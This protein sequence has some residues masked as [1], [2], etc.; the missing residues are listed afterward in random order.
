MHMVETNGAKIPALGLGTWRLTGSE[1]TRLVKEALRLGYRHFDT[2]EMYENEAEIGRGIRESGVRREEVFVT[3]KIWSTHLAPKAFVNAT[4]A[5]IKRL[6]T[7]YIDLLEIHW[8]NPRVPLAETMGALCMMKIEGYARHIGVSNFSPALLHEAAMHAIEPLATNQIEWHPFIDQ[9]ASI[10]ACRRLGIAVTAF[11]PQA[12]GKASSNAIMA[13]IGKRY[14]K[15]GGQVS[16]R[17]LLQQGAIVIPGTSKVER[18]RELIDVFDFELTREEMSEIAGLRDMQTTVYASYKNEEAASDL[19]Y[20]SG[21]RHPETL[22]KQA[23]ILKRLFPQLK[24]DFVQPDPSRLPAHAEG[25]V[26]VPRWQAIGSTYH[27]ALQIV[28]DTIAKRRKGEFWNLRENQMDPDQLRQSVK[29]VECWECIERAQGGRDMLVIPAQFGMRHRGRSVRRARL[30]MAD[31]EFGLGA[32][33]V[34]IMLLT[35]PQRMQHTEDLWLDCPGDEFHE[36]M[37]PNPPFNRAPY[38]R[39]LKELGFGAYNGKR[40]AAYFGSVSGWVVT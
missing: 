34:G 16:L 11:T 9:T 1:C 39:F 21:Y 25:Y 40:A 32:F 7:D 5:S 2:A 31:G 13:A 22:T 33:A 29:S 15:T 10:G 12:K 26:I 18:L 38:F 35:H 3:T 14:G 17:W 6:R 36:L 8:P 19:G 27:A 24:D 20:R 28:L 37:L 4:K 30:V 23:R